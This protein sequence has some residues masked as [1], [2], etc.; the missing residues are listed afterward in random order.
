MAKRV[1]QQAVKYLKTVY[2]VWKRLLKLPRI[3]EWIVTART[4]CRWVLLKRKFLLPEKVLFNFVNRDSGGFT[5][6]LSLNY[7]GHNG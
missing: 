1:I 4:K 3:W 2:Q 7:G 6:P 5:P